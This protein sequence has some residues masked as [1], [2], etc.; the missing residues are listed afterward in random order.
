MGYYQFICKIIGQGSEAAAPGDIYQVCPA[1]GYDTREAQIAEC[2]R[3]VAEIALVQESDVLVHLV[4]EMYPS[5]S[6]KLFADGPT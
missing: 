2:K 4:E 1:G 6:A 5:G 3:V